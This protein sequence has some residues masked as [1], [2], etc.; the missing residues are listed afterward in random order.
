MIAHRRNVLL[1]LVFNFLSFYHSKAV[2]LEDSPQG[3]ALR[4][5]LSIPTLVTVCEILSKCPPN[6]LDGLEEGQTLPDEVRVVPSS[7]C[8]S[9]TLLLVTVD[10]RDVA[11]VQLKD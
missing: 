6:M 8:K 4:I 11:F 7:A 9:L 5:G 1:A 2:T 10:S 3:L